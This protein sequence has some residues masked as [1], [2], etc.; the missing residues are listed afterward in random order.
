MSLSLRPGIALGDGRVL[1][2]AVDPLFVLSLGGI[3]G[4]TTGF[5]GALDATGAA[6][7]TIA[8]PPG[9]PPGV[10]VHVSAVAVNQALPAGLDMGNSWSLSSL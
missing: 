1:N 2:L 8:L 9:F 6:A 4:L 7:G 5:S 3:P 10:R